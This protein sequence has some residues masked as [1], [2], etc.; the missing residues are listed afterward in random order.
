MRIEPI[1]TTTET[2]KTKNTGLKRK[3]I[4]FGTYNP[5]AARAIEE[6]LARRGILCDAKGND[7]LAECYKN[8]VD[9]FEK[10]FGTSRLPSKL[11]FKPLGEGVYGMFDKYPNE[12]TLN[13][14]YDFKCFYD[15]DSLKEESK[16]HYN[17]ILPGWNST[18]HPAH[19]FV[20]EFSHAAHWNHLKDKHGRAKAINV[21]EGLHYT[22]VPTGIGKLITK[23]KISGYAEKGNMKEFLAE[24]MTKDI[25][26]SISD[27][28]WWPYKDIDVDYSHIFSK[29]WN[30]R[31]SSPQSYIDYFTQQVWDGDIDEAK[32][33]G[34]MA[35]AYLAELEGATKTAPL[36]NKIAKAIDYTPSW[37]TPEDKPLL[38]KIGTWLSRT[39]VD[40]N[41]EVT[42]KLDRDNQLK[43]NL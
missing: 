32:R 25:C 35:G 7:F 6:N 26:G 19:V 16:K 38:Y 12:V 40:T 29:K 13:E 20:H 15:M 4:T 33:A 11:S 1:I 31:Y 37:A 2:T 34:D 21:M 22:S 36:I 43:L 8:T 42:K 39:L 14:Q 41:E 5:T 30:Y 23:F 18:K 27:S 28:V 3:G 17:W 24:R 10:L 9:L